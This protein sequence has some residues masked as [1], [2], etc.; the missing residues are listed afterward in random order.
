MRSKKRTDTA[1]NAVLIV[2]AAIFVISAIL[3]VIT[4]LDKRNGEFDGSGDDGNSI[5]YE[6]K[7]Y[8]RRDTVESFLVMGL[9]KYEGSDHAE[10]HESGTQTD[11]IMLFVFDN[12][13]KECS[14]ININRD[15]MVKINKLSIGGATVVESFTKQIALAQNFVADDNPKIKCR[16]TKDS[17]EALLKGAR[18]NHY[19]SFTMDLVPAANDAVGGVELEVMCDFLDDPTM[20]AGASVRLTGAQ[21]LKYVRSRQGLEDASNTARMERQ[22]QFIDCFIAQVDPKTKDDA[23]Y[24]INLVDTLDDYV[25]Y[26]SSDSRMQKFVEKF[27]SYDF[28]GIIDLPGESKISDGF[29]EFYPDT[30]SVNKLVVDLF[31]KEKK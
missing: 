18:V 6:G 5:I 22:K 7:E 11:F 31:Y 21:A 29:M 28:K 12:D 27:S 19:L 1:I 23:N 17:V 16:N 2:L 14:A 9:D 26:D 25:V 24:L 8:L 13:K 30:A 10:S 15:T 4:V 3:L 20:H